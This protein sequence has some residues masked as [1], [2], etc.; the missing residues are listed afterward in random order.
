[1]AD[2][3]SIMI[4]GG[5]SCEELLSDILTTVL[6]FLISWGYFVEAFSRMVLCLGWKQT[7]QT[8]CR[9]FLFITRLMQVLIH[10]NNIRKAMKTNMVFNSCALFMCKATLTSRNLQHEISSHPIWHVSRVKE[11]SAL[12]TQ[13][14]DSINSSC[15]DLIH[16]FHHLSG[17]LFF[18]DV[19]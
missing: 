5:W 9:M 12:V 6:L 19:A 11:S 14:C 4:K 3:I 8:S 7:K 2:N 18:K 15:F 13:A 16:A 1:M 17:S 10:I